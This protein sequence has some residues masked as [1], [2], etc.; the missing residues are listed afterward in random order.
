MKPS[1]TQ[2]YLKTQLTYNPKEGLF[3]WH[4][5]IVKQNVIGG[6]LAG[7][8]R[9]GSPSNAKILSRNIEIDGKCYSAKKLA[10]IYVYGDAAAKLKY[11][12]I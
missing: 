5:D 7:N 6:S 3:Y 10:F 8:R 11:R 12:K 1:I 4:N 2:E 9:I